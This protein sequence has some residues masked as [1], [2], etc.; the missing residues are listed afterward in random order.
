MSL[1]QLRGTNCR[2]HSL[3]TTVPDLIMLVTVEGPL[4]AAFL[5]KSFKVNQKDS[6]STAHIN[7]TI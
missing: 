3:V 2:S 1:A 6:L 5:S 4:A 7:F